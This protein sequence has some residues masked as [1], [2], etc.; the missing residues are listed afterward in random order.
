[1]RIR[2]EQMEAFEQAARQ[3]FEEEMIEHSKNF[4][5]PICEVI[6]DEQ[7]RV[8]LRAAM[9]RADSYGFTY[10]GPI[11]LFIEMMFLCGSSFDTDPQYPAIAQVLRSPADQMQRAEQIHQGYL[12]YLERVSG[13]DAENVHKALK[14][15]L[16]FART[17][18]TFSSD[19]ASDMLREMNRIFPQKTAY[20]GEPGLR[21]LIDEGIEEARAYYFPTIRETALLVI[22]KYSFGHGCTDDPL[23]PWISRTLKDEKIVD[24]TARAARLEKKALTWLEHVVA[25]NEGR[26]A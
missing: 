21:A 3:R 24:P 18:V 26:S 11:R 7:L 4:A 6:G 19:F 5:P 1:M 15:L 17:P 12:D 9:A 16:A 2:S 25:R 14:D 20:V 23:Y 22:L 10:R 8:A 13:P